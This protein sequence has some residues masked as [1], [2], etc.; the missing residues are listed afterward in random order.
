MKKYL[1]LSTA[2]F[3][4][5][6]LACSVASFLV[7]QSLQDDGMLLPAISHIVLEHSLWILLL[8]VP[9]IV[10]SSAL[11]CTRKLNP[12]GV[13]FFSGTLF[14]A[15]AILVSVTAIGCLLPWLVLT[16]GTNNV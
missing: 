3:G 5:I 9:W 8:P 11:S 14:L 6:C 15:V 2:A 12:N 1:W 10:Y 13:Y 7:N 16:N 4:L